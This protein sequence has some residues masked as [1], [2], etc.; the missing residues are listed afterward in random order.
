MSQQ[1]ATV[2]LLDEPS[3]APSGVNMAYF[4]MSGDDAAEKMRELFSPNQIDQQIRQAIQFCWMGLPKEKRSV[5]ELERQ[6]RRMVDRALRDCR[7]D[8][9]EFFGT[10]K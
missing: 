10:A 5:D 7:D 3:Q 2:C 8:F 6:I 1:V 4:D 9:E